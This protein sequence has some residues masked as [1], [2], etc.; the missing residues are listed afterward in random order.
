M[1]FQHRDSAIINM[2]YQNEGVV[3]KRQIKAQFWPGKNKR[4]ME[5]RL[6][7]LH[8]AGYI[9]WPTLEQHQNYPIPEPICWLG[10][11][12]AMHIASSYGVEVQPPISFNE[13][14]LRRFQKNLRE[15]GIRWVRQPR[16]SLLRHDIAVTDVKLAVLNVAERFTRFSLAKWI[17]E[18]VF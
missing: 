18:G 12:G 14:R 8:N 16:W 2:I 13:N 9:S 1:R 4:T 11:K 15:E 17:S 3:A 6:A 7:K 10:W 5:I